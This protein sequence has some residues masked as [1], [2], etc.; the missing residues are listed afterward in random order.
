VSRQE[1]RHGALPH[2]AARAAPSRAGRESGHAAVE[3]TPH[4]A[5]EGEPM[6]SA[7]A[8]EEATRLVLGGA[9]VVVGGF[10]AAGTPERPIEA[11]VARRA[12]GLTVMAND[13]APPGPMR[14]PRRMNALPQGGGP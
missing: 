3:A 13:T 2:A 10:L 4:T 8:A 14:P 12:R 9:T 7:V 5:R 6:R 1:G 11:L